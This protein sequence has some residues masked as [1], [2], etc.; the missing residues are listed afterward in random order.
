MVR[1]FWRVAPLVRQAEAIF[2]ESRPAALT[3]LCRYRDCSIPDVALLLDQSLWHG[4][5]AHSTPPTRY[6]SK[7]VPPR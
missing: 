5:L 7:K 2:E 6:Q 1:D 4:E 3:L